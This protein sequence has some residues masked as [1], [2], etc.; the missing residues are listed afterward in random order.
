[1]YYFDEVVL[2]CYYCVDV[3][4]GYWDFVDDV[5]V[6]LVFDVLCCFC[7]I[8]GGEVVFGFGMVY[9]L[10]CVV[11]VWVEVFWVVEFVYDEVFCVYWIWNDFELFFLCGYC[12]FVCDEYVFVEVVF[13][14]YVVVVVVYCMCVDWEWC[15]DYVVCCV[16]YCVYYCLLVVLCVVLCLVD[17]FDVIVEVLVV[18]GE[19][20]EIMV[21]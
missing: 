10:V 8:V 16:D 11:V 5:C 15:V 1:M 20:C 4:V 6:F 7:L 21:G 9:C 19:V 13:V 12:V 2:G 14:L 17:C 18:F 3:F